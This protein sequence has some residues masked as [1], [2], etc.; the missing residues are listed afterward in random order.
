MDRIPIALQLYSIREDCAR[1][2]EGSIK[3]VAEMGY[4]GVEFA[5]YYQRGADE[6]KSLCDAHGLQIVGTHIG[7]DTLQ[8]DA[9]EE[10]VEFNK[11]LGNRYLIVPG[12]SEERRNSRAAWLET[13]GL[14]DEIAAR[15][16]PHDMQTGYHNHHIEFAEMEGELPWDTFFGNTRQDV[17]MQLDTGNMYHGG[18]EPVGFL[19]RYPGRAQLVHLKEHSSSND[20]ALIGEGE[21]EWARVFEI[22]ESSGATEW[23]IVEQESYAYAPLEC[24]N[25]CLQNLKNMDK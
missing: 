11:T 21:V 17:V 16:E 25:R 12:L 7:L 6:L 19:Q 3:A 2:L 9:L 20:K 1:D 13:A 8:G 14:F 10:T 15:L 23:Y 18:A 22:C 24:V 4:E 5:G